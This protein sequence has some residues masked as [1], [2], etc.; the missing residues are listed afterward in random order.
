MTYFVCDNQRK[1]TCYHEFYKGEWDQQTFWKAD[2]ISLHDDLMF[3]GFADA[4]AE[5]IP[6]Y[7]PYG[8]TEISQEDWKEIGRI[9]LTKD[10][11]SQEVYNEADKWLEEVFRT[12]SCFT[13][14][15]I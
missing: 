9:I 10:Q 3:G 15:G 1:G 2:S 14:L 4:I 11:V 8:E 13:I 7:D 6:S 5:V 12:H